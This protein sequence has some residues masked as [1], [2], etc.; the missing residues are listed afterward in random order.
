MLYASIY[1]FTSRATGKVYVGSTTKQW[2]TDRKQGHLYML[3]RGKHANHILQ[4][5]YDKHGES[6]LIFAVIGAA[7]YADQRELRETEGRAIRNVPKHLRMNHHLYP[8]INPMLGKTASAETREK[9]RLSHLGQ[10]PDAAARARQS[11]AKLGHPT[12]AE[13][14]AKIGAA[15][16][17]MK[18]TAETKQRISEVHKG[19]PNWR[20]KL[21]QAQADEIRQLRA[22]GFTISD[23][24][25]KY[26]VDR[27]G[28]RD[29]VNGRCYV[30]Q[31]EA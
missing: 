7:Y 26:G 9:L 22:Q 27:K 1:K 25:R 6:D 15:H 29:I 17:G 20:R 21:T 19:K 28:I 10:K 30:T 13:T 23:L 2:A 5:I 3:R 11:K 4:A 31:D 14:R 24:A 8:D 12:S 16:K 18:H